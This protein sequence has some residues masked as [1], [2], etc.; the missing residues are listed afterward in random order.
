MGNHEAGVSFFFK[1]TTYLECVFFAYPQLQS[2][3]TRMVRAGCTS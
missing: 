1:S 3:G 2:H